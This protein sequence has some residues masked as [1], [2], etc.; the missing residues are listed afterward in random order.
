MLCA[1]ATNGLTETMTTAIP[2]P[3]KTFRILSTSLAFGASPTPLQNPVLPSVIPTQR[4][5]DHVF[6]EGQSGM[7][8]ME[9]RFSGLWGWE[10]RGPKTQRNVP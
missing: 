3:N 9:I 5:L 4:M 6:A 8:R 10:V 1:W 2:T 7:P